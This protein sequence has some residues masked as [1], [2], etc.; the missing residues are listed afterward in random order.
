M[1]GRYWHSMAYGGVGVSGGGELIIYGGYDG[2]MATTA[3]TA[4]GELECSFMTYD[5][6]VNNHNFI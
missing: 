3:P 1:N 6:D 5:R 2:A 4:N